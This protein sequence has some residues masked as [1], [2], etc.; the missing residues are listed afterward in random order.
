MPTKL[1]KK[2]RISLLRLVSTSNIYER[3][4]LLL[5]DLK[6]MTT[7][8]ITY[9]EISQCDMKLTLHGITAYDKAARESTRRPTSFVPF[10][11]SLQ[12][13]SFLKEIAVFV[14]A[15]KLKKVW[16]SLECSHFFSSHM[17]EN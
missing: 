6:A 16:E 1:K 14:V 13:N 7:M 4:Q 3:K 5:H 15:A 11:S 8:V 12:L 2:A 10:V 17:L 9:I